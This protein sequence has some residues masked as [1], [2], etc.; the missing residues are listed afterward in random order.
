MSVVVIAVL[1]SIAVP[2]MSHFYERARLVS[3]TNTLYQDLF[4]ARSEAIKRDADVYVKF[5]T[6]SS[7]C[8]ALS[9]ATAL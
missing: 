4:F 2:A 3:A 7:W 6:G 1:L 5:T 8:Y 9:D